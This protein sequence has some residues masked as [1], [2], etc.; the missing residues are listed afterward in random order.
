MQLFRAK[1]IMSKS[2][3]GDVTCWRTKWSWWLQRSRSGFTEGLNAAVIAEERVHAEL[4]HFPASAVHKLCPNP[5]GCCFDYVRALICGSLWKGLNTLTGCKMTREGEAW[6]TYT[7][8]EAEMVGSGVKESRGE[9]D[10]PKTEY[11]RKR[12]GRK[13]M[14]ERGE[15]RTSNRDREN[16]V[17]LYLGQFWKIVT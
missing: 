4:E 3:G 1:V 10:T 12:E 15:T 5:Q 13:Q 2:S 14:I 8:Q 7:D 11:E 17:R 6:P 9:G 16:A